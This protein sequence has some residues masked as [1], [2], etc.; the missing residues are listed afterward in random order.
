[1]TSVRTKLKKLFRESSLYHEM[2]VHEAREIIEQNQPFLDRQGS[3]E[4]APYLLSAQKADL[5]QEP[6]EDIQ[7]P[8]RFAFR[9]S[10]SA[11]CEEQR[12]WKDIIE[13]DEN[14]AM[15]TDLRWSMMLKD[16]KNK[17]PVKKL[18]KLIG[19]R[20][21]QIA[22]VGKKIESF[23]DI[24]SCLEKNG[25]RKERIGELE[26]YME[27]YE[28]DEYNDNQQK[29]QRN[30]QGQKNSI[31]DEIISAR[32]E[33][34]ICKQTKLEIEKYPNPEP[35]GDEQED[36]PTDDSDE[37]KAKM[38][39]LQGSPSSEQDR[40]EEKSQS[41]EK[42]IEDL[43]EKMQQLDRR[44]DSLLK[45]LDDIQEEIKKED[46]ESLKIR[47]NLTITRRKLD[48]ERS[49]E[50][51]REGTLEELRRQKTQ[52][53][54]DS[55]RLQNEKKEA[56]QRQADLERKMEELG[57]W[58]KNEFRDLDLSHEYGDPSA[59]KLYSHLQ[60]RYLG[61]HLDT[62]QQERLKA[63]REKVKQR[64]KQHQLSVNLTDGEIDQ[65]LGI[66]CSLFTS[67][68]LERQTK[69]AH[70]VYK[71]VGQDEFRV[72]VLK[73]APNDY[74][75][76]IGYLHRDRLSD[77]VDYAA[78]SYNWGSP[79]KLDN[80]I[81]LLPEENTPLDKSF[82]LRIR[83]NLFCR[84]DKDIKIW[85][86]ALCINQDDPS[87]KTDQ[88]SKVAQ[89]YSL[90]R[91]VCIWL[92]E[93]DNHN[94]S[95]RAMD[96]IPQLVDMVSLDSDTTDEQQAE[97]WAALSYLI[98]DPWFSRRWIVQEI[99][100]AR[101]ATVH[102]GKRVV[103]WNTLV[104]AISILVSH[105]DS[106]RALFKPSK[107]RFGHNTLGEIQYSSANILVNVISN[108]FPMT[109]DGSHGKPLKSLE[110]LVTTL[111]TF[112]AS[113]PRDI[114][115]ALVYLAR[116]TADHRVQLGRHDTGSPSPDGKPKLAVNYHKEP[117]E[118]Y[119][120]F[121]R[122][123]TESTGSL[124][125]ICR[126]WAKP[127]G[128]PLPSWIPSLENAE[129]GRPDSE[130]RGRKN[131]QSLLGPVDQPV[132][133]ASGASK[134]HAVFEDGRLLKAKGISL[135]TITSVSLRS[136]S[137]MVFRE[138]LEL[139][140]WNGNEQKPR[141]VPDRIWR[142]LIA[143]RDLNKQR[144]PLWYQR[145]CMRSLEIADTFSNGDLNTTQLSNDLSF[146]RDYLRRVRDVTWNRC[147]FNAETSLHGILRPFH[148]ETEDDSPAGIEPS[149]GEEPTE[150]GNTPTP[151]ANEQEAVADKASQQNTTKIS[152]K[153]QSERIPNQ[154]TKPP[155]TRQSLYGL[156]P[157]HTQQGDYVCILFGCSVP[158][159]LRPFNTAGRDK[160]ELVGEAYVHGKM[161]GEAV[162]DLEEEDF[163]N[164]E[165]FTMC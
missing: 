97:Q 98:R 80:N 54:D 103:H 29:K 116:D 20:D 149:G 150:V 114:I 77:A 163:E 47:T 68:S 111:Q 123:C 131:G 138:S 58:V 99:S 102:C 84:K 125:I 52:H 55:R 4:G 92:G 66:H 62:D 161:N 5:P 43:E 132:Y 126:P 63:L 141:T 65:L 147:F 15:L 154:S 31:E 117:V 129:F 48:D 44:T 145:A 10:S 1:M 34:S 135:G 115:Y 25:N 107:W 38:A 2:L 120:D 83:N 19:V 91:R 160:F 78:L 8:D 45:R 36:I 73:K 56:T 113:D 158:V 122:F 64:A 165:V 57:H 109:E 33:T 144:P 17:A 30:L 94:E 3:A 151:K 104:D 162:A 164:A 11:F 46:D 39:I 130:N 128:E 70:G 155:Q 133:C 32:I 106:I 142:T 72:L 22:E 12:V 13:S 6:P 124:D 69:V 148:A 71:P 105:E 49:F 67:Q 143:D 121:T 96:F 7:V 108:L 140:G 101:Y 119:M 28:E 27:K 156:C 79:L 139:G 41:R 89:I 26:R 23:S 112:D 93:N 61:I 37:A 35:T 18:E 134:A 157:P 14:E 127:I 75:P 51:K 136:T 53:E 153:T 76:L 81:Y 159:V 24:E 88:L 152:D 85:V 95:H 137:G 146:L 16:W 59:A 86:D 90:A 82:S 118:V 21:E 74:E 9:E 87:E 40:P 50:N 60:Y 42:Q 100:H 110:Y